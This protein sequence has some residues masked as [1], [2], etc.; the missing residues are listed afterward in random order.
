MMKYTRESLFNYDTHLKALK[1]II[2]FLEKNGDLGGLHKHAVEDIV[3]LFKTETP[4]IMEMEV[5][6]TWEALGMCGLRKDGD[7]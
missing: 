5:N 6:E 7:D 4:Y 2:R 1:S 3:H